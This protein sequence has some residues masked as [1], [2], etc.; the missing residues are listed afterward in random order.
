VT[1]LVDLFRT[2]SAASSVL[3][4]A[5]TAALGLAIGSVR[6]RGVSFGIAGVLFSGLLFGHFGA[7]IA[8][9]VLEFARD[10]GLILFVYA[11]G[12]EVGPG[13]ASSL[14]RHGLP[15]NMIAAGTVAAGAALAVVISRAVGI[16]IPVAAG[17]FSGATTNTPSLGAAQAALS[18]MPGYVE[19][20]A[21]L[22]GLGY[23]VS[24]PFGLLGV[25]LSVAVVRA[26]FCARADSTSAPVPAEDPPAT[27]YRIAADSESVPGVTTEIVPERPESLQVLPVFMGIALGVLVG[28]IPIHIASLPAPLR[29]GMA[30]GPLVVAIALGAIGRLGPLNWRM[31]HAVDATFREVGIVMFLSCVGLRSGSTFMETLLHGD[32]LTWMAW[33]TLITLVPL[34]AATL[35]ARATMGIS[36]PALCGL[37]TGSMTNPAGLAFA[38]S[39]NHSQET[40]QCYATVYPL[41]M[42]L[43]VIAAQLIV[44]LFMR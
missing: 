16:A 25:I 24:Y 13:F 36:Y 30:G 34:I 44:L 10:F 38:Q 14:R 12:I 6:V 33:A 7:T 3:V 37:L 26:A 32:G 18:E 23:A 39:L 11:I 22:P 27:A 43:R 20:M 19:S 9:P 17:I 2:G 4:L 31:P 15:L 28:G 41:T 42:V 8:P 1:W 21:R 5:L 35:V 29:L 40:T